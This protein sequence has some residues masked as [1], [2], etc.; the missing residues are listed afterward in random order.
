VVVMATRAR[1]N[2]RSSLALPMIVLT[3]AAAA[4]GAAVFALTAAAGAAFPPVSRGIVAASA[5]LV[6][7]AAAW[8]RSRPWQRDAE[9][10]TQWLEHAGLR[11]AVWNGLALGAGFFT[12]LGFWIWWALPVLV[13]ES[14]S[15]SAGAVVGAAYGAVRLGGSSLVAARAEAARSDRLPRRLLGWRPRAAVIADPLFFAASGVALAVA[16]RLVGFDAWR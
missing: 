9:T 13:F 15:V 7:A 8:R 14:G 3:I 6:L 16:A 4:A 11:V 10:P 1:G 5:S 12:R 2:G